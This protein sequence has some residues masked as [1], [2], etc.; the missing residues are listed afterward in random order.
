MAAQDNVVRLYVTVDHVL[1]VV[2]VRKSAEEASHDLCALLLWETAL[3]RL[4]LLS[5]QVT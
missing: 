5:L 1:L 2:E 3:A 4:L